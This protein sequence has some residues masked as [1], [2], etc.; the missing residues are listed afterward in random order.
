MQGDAL[1]V[2][3]TLESESVQVC[4]TSPPY[5]GLR[6]YGVDGQVGLERT[7]EAYVARLVDIFQG[8]R[9]VLH[10]SG[11]CWVNLGDSYARGNGSKNGQV[12]AGAK[13]KTNGGAMAHARSGKIVD[14]CK[15]K[16]LVGIPW[17]FAFAMRADGWHLRSEITWAK[18]APMPESA[19]D[20]PSS[21]T[22]KI[23]LFSKRAAYF[24]DQEA[25]RTPLAD[26]RPGGR[27]T[28]R[29]GVDVKGGNQAAGYIPSDAAGANL[30]NWWGFVP[31][32]EP[33]PVWVLGPEP[34]REAHFAVF[35]SEV[36]RRCVLLG[37]S[38]AGCCP[39]CLA[40]W[41]RVVE[42]P[43]LPRKG[44][45]RPS[46][47][48]GGLTTGNSWDRTGLTHYGVDQWYKKNP[49]R[50]TGWGPGCDCGGESAP[51]LVL[52]PFLGSGT[53]LLA[54]KAL[55]RRGVG[56]ELNAD[57]ATIARRRLASAGLTKDATLPPRESD[58]MALFG[59]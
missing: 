24:Y 45:S 17:A 18:T 53:T 57:Y 16:D 38:E 42:R 15:D 25:G 10:P 8:V 14:G 4:V 47:R 22:E 46:E 30:R 56:V 31:E 21:A 27:M 48:D 29:E 41:R 3:R 51:C 6:D 26:A 58:R 33:C 36:P 9:R 40:P 11:T 49:T 43:R 39:A 5:Y 23:F 32:D 52:D 19:R 35:P 50:T 28:A 55:G 1:A 13:Q 2:L 7:P 37:T 54:A 34:C 44:E 59:E 20:R 12:S